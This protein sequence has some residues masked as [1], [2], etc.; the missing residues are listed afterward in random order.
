MHKKADVESK[1]EPS[2]MDRFNAALRQVLSVPKSELRRLL[3]E[4]K[5]SKIGK[6]KPGP[7]PK[8]SVSAP[9]FRES[10]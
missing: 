8:T 2:H 5:A 10:N 1:L 3:D 9:A 4:E 7:K 6:L